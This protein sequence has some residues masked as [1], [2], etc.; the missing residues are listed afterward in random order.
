MN[1]IHPTAIVHSGANISPDVEIGAYSIIEEGVEIG[2]GTKIFNH[3]TINRGAKIGENNKIY[4]HAVIAAFPQDL[5][6]TGEYTECIIGDG[7][8]IRECVTISRATTENHKT[9]IG[10]NCLFMAYSHAAHDNII[11]NNCIFANS[12]ALA[13]HV[14]IQDYAILG[15]LVGVHQ[16]VKIG[17]YTMIG[18]HSMIVKDVPPFTL[19]SGNPC[20]FE[21]LNNI[22]LRRRGF[23]DESIEILKKVFKIIYSSGLNVSQAISKVKEAIQN[24]DDVNYLIDFIETSKRGITK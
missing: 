2:K 6:F 16:F 19:F 18:A 13:G 20:H 24:N 9:M 1:K 14:E 3:V 10:N 22:G 8:I 21:G 11:G 15:G 7:N 12:V 4:P 17:K 5:K 23:N